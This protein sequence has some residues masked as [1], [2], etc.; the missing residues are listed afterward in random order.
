MNWLLLIGLVFAK[1]TG[2]VVVVGRPLTKMAGPLAGAKVTFT[3][4]V[5]MAPVD[6]VPMSRA[7]RAQ[8]RVELKPVAGPMQ[9]QTAQILDPDA[10]R[11]RVPLQANWQEGARVELHLIVTGDPLPTKIQALLPPGA[12]LENEVWILTAPKGDLVVDLPA[13]G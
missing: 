3:L 13:C 4:D 11:F 12:K 2:K 6:G 8:T 1:P 5:E 9:Q 10:C 7:R